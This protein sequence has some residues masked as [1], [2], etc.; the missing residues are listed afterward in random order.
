MNESLGQHERS[1]TFTA[2]NKACLKVQIKLSW[3]GVEL[4][5]WRIHYFVRQLPEK[6]QL[7]ISFF[8]PMTDHLWESTRSINYSCSIFPRHLFDHALL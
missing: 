2:K 3:K 6:K 1:G 4:Q 8:D 5:V 7:N